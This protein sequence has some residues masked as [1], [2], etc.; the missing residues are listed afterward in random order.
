MGLREGRDHAELCWAMLLR[1]GRRTPAHP[2]P[3]GRGQLSCGGKQLSY[4]IS[5]APRDDT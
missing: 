4:L 1:E 3:R 2:L 5:A